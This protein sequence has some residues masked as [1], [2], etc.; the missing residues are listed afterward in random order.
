MTFLCVLAVWLISLE[1]RKNQE[2]V[3]NAVLA[4]IFKR[5]YSTSIRLIATLGLAEVLY[6]LSQRVTTKLYYSGTKF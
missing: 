5:L 3:A 1:V 6:A 2:I 4:K